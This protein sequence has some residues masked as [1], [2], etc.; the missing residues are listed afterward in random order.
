MIE[1]FSSFSSS[2][3][4]K[5]ARPKMPSIKKRKSPKYICLQKAEGF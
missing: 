4:E 1:I 2:Y 5:G 3:T